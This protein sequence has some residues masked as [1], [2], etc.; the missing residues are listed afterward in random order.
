MIFQIQII[1]ITEDKPLKIKVK[2]W[3]S[4]IGKDEENVRSNGAVSFS[5]P[6][7]NAK[8]KQESR[9]EG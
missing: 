7:P 6:I 1:F 2:L 9:V 3:D 4:L 8:K 5:W